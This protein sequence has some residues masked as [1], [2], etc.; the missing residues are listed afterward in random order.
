MYT[1]TYIYIYIYKVRVPQRRGASLNVG[2]AAAICM[3]EL[4]RGARD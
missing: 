2:A 4:S 1:Y 3:Y